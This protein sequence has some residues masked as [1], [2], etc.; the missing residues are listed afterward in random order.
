MKKIIILGGSFDPIHKGHIEI[1]NTARKELNIDEGWLMLAKRPRWKNNYSSTVFRLKLLNRVCKEEKHL[2]V[3]KEE[4][5][6]KG[7]SLT[8]N[9][10][11]KLT[12]KYPDTKFYFLIGSD[13]LEVLH[14]WYNIDELAKICQ[15]VVIKRPNYVLNE[16]NFKK[17]NCILIDYYGPDISSTEFKKNLNLDLIPQYLHNLIIENGCYYKA[18]LR[19]MINIKRY[20]HSLQVA[21]LAKKIAKANNYN[22]N[23]AFLAALLHDCAKDI[24]NSIEMQIMQNHFPNHLNEKSLVYHQYV[25]AYI[26]KDEFS[27]NDKDIIDAIRCHTTGEENMSILSKIVF[28][29]DKI[30]P[31]RGFDSSEM[32]EEC[33]NDIEKGFLFVLNENYKFLVEKKGLKVE[34]SLATKKCLEYYKII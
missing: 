34:S 19:K 14:K 18:K 26:I 1:I 6:D 25:G 15:L 5:K 22:E 23:K 16:E 20:R 21:I 4:L 12:T 17:Y 7:V 8:Y 10:M 2:K 11:M 28:V 27:I 9:T 13:Q 33:M 29:S 30:E 31:T 24:S 3:C 32:I